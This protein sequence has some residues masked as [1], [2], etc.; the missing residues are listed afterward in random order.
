[1]TSKALN[2]AIS[3]RKT[4]QALPHHSDRDAQY[5]SDLHQKQHYLLGD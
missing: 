4:A 5:C 3:E 1:V 2:N